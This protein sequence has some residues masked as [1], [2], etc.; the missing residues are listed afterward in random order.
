[1]AAAPYH[2]ILTRFH[3][4][5]AQWV[6]RLPDSISYEEGALLEP[7]VVALAGIDRSGLRLGQPLLICG[8]G[9]IGLVTLLAAAAAGASPIVITDIST[10][11]LEFA[12]KICPRAVTVQIDTE[13][14]PKAQAAKIKEAAGMPLHV[15][16][17]AT[18]VE[19]SISTATHC[20]K[21]GSVLEVV[22]LAQPVWRNFPFAHC[23]AMEIDLRFLFRYA[24]WVRI[25]EI[26][27]D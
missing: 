16:I 3:A 23:S 18:G 8:A 21:F 11:R 4:H 20:L 14:D 25:T 22:G 13:L 10:S 19:S 6:H 17:E 1:M 24:K 5:P 15:A 27:S 2:G 26:R 9:P 7:L 12:Q